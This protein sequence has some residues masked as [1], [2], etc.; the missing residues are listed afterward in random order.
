MD[1]RS[2]QDEMAGLLPYLRL[3][4]SICGFYFPPYMQSKIALGEEGALIAVP[5]HIVHEVKPVTQR[6]RYTIMSWF[7]R[8]TG[9]DS[10]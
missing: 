10:E 5:S 1:R 8:S 2:K 6:E 4:A 3:S 9:M 7:L